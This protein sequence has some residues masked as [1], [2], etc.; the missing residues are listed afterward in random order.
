M[1]D[2]V[3]KEWLRFAMGRGLGDGDDCSLTQVQEKFM[4]SGGNFDALL[5]A[6]IA[7]DTFRTRPV[8]VAP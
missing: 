3:S 7:S 5:L 1:H 8:E 2:C 4:K 6:I